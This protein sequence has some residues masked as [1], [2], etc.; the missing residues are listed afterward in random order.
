MPFEALIK[1]LNI[2]NCRFLVL[3]R[4]REV[5]AGLGLI[6]RGD[7]GPAGTLLNVLLLGGRRIS[8]NK[9]QPAAL[10]LLPYYEG[11]SLRCNDPTVKL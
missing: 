6:D 4:A 3:R 9:L 10:P 2:V 11:V 5:K 1:G 8:V 7:I